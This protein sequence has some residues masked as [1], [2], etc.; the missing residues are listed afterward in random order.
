MTVLLSRRLILRRARAADLDDLHAI[1]A[2]PETM[3]YWSTPPHAERAVTDK[4]LAGMTPGPDMQGDEFI[5][6]HDG[7]CIGKLGIWQSSEVGFI[8]ARA[9]WGQGFATEALK[10]FIQYAFT[11]VTDH[12]TADVD[13]L[14]L[15]SLALL[16][17]VGFVETG[18]AERTW[19]IAG[20]WSDSVYLRLDRR[21]PQM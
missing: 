18:R 8:L 7:A 13:P 21:S 6:E 3:R 17:R 5:I 14:N 2:D 10:V 15:V 11:H 1:M 12:L 9:F 16:R 4:F 20:V 19:N